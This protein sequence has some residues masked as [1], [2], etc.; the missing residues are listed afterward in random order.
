MYIYTFLLIM[1]DIMTSQNSDLP[2]WDI[3]YTL[4]LCFVLLEIV[5]NVKQ[6]LIFSHVS[7]YTRIL[8][9]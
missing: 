3:L 9:W 6:Y 8:D 5:S 2:S 1:T 4:T 7:D